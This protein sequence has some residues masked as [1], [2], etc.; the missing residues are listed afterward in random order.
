MNLIPLF[1]R[2]ADEEAEHEKKVSMAHASLLRDWL[3]KS[4]S[5]E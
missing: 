1:A 4:T 3:E 2:L 5:S